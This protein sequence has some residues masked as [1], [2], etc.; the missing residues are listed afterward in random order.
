MIIFDQ[1][2]K[3][4]LN[5]LILLIL[6]IYLPH[7]IKSFINFPYH[8]NLSELLTNYQGGFIRRGILGELILKAYQIFKINPLTLLSTVFLILFLVK[9]FILFKLLEKY[10]N[11]YFLLIFILLGPVIILFSIYDIGA[12]LLKDK[13]INILILI[14]AFAVSDFI[15]KKKSITSYNYFLIIFLIPGLNFNFLMHENQLF[16]LSVH[17]L[18]S[19]YVYQSLSNSSFLKSKYIYSYLTIFISLFLISVDSSAILLQKISLI[20]ISLLENFPFIY[21][22]F[23]IEKDFWSYDELVGNFN[24]KIGG[25]MKLFLYFDHTGSINTFIAFILSVVLIFMVFHYRL[26]KELNDLS[27]RLNFNYWFLLLPCL[28]VALVTTDFG[29]AFNMISIHFLAFYLIFPKKINSKMV[30][31]FTQNKILD[32]YLF[33]IFLFFY[34]L[35]WTMPHAVGW[36]GQRIVN[37]T[38]AYAGSLPHKNTSL[39]IELVNLSKNTYKI[40]DNYLIA[41]PKADFMKKLD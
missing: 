38:T 17:I 6:F 31:I 21:E 7:I 23:P 35:F 30:P 33:C 5:I 32:N 15:K 34:C 20:K 10:R 8:F 39:G 12:Y 27:K 29:R 11:N 13:F 25:F 16:F 9:I 2:K 14:H 40:V 19:F 36:E 41:L 3:F 26:S 22:K 4:F 1:Y 18:I 37:S 24:L 28:L